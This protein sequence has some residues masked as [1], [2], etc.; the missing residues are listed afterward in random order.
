[1]AED[2]I[3]AAG[4]WEAL[5]KLSPGRRRLAVER[6]RRFWNW[7]LAERLSEESARAAAHRADK[8]VELA[9]LARRVAE[10]TP[11]SEDLRSGLLGWVWAFEANALRVQGDL[12]GA[13]EA[14]L[15]SDRLLAAGEFADPGLLDATRPLDLKASL[16]RYQG[17]FG[18]ALTLLEQALKSNGSNEA[19]G[20]ILIKKAN[21]L[22][23]MGDSE[24]ALAELRQAERL[25]DEGAQDPRLVLVVQH[26]LAHSL[27]QLGR[28]VEAEARL[29]GVRKLAVEIGNEL[30]LIR[31]LW[32]EG[33]VAAGLGRRGQA[34]AALEE[35]RRYFND[36]RIAYD[37]ALATLEVAVLY[38][39]EE[40]TAEVK[41][42]ADEM[43][44]IF[45]A[46][47][48][49]KEA[50]AALLLFYEAAIKEEATS[51]QARRL[52]D[53]LTKARCTPGLRFEPQ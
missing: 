42:L 15:R 8:A 49:H 40:R 31:V 43:F 32:V 47:G 44:W 9:R 3:A 25:L 17:R 11:G 27:W 22:R 4:L 46:Q 14:F 50:I 6:E 38:L 19:K 12:P 1:M 10:L 53:Y 37:A 7:A 48:V 24:R 34:L 36:K 29:P 45:K 35:V 51:A 21:T 5:K 23:H 39:D 26:S 16:R 52:A 20:R 2:R 33:G 41:K 30:D 28:Y 13:A 18:E